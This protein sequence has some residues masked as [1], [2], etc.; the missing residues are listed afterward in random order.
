MTVIWLYS[1]SAAVS[2]RR[3]KPLS[4]FKCWYWQN[5]VFFTVHGTQTLSQRQTLSRMLRMLGYVSL[6]VKMWFIQNKTEHIQIISY[7][8]SGVGCPHL[9]CCWGCSAVCIWQ[10]REPES[11]RTPAWPAPQRSTEPDW[12]PSLCWPGQCGPWISAGPHQPGVALRGTD[13]TETVCEHIISTDWF[14][15]EQG[16]SQDHVSHIWVN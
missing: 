15:K 2:I 12:A 4:V 10:T 6:Y 3:V 7:V 13:N 1:I 8:S 14:S 11:R 16:C 5:E 9:R